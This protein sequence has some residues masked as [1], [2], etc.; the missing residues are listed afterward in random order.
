MG[1]KP[2]HNPVKGVPAPA[3]G[4][5]SV[6]SPQPSP[7]RR[8]RRRMPLTSSDSLQQPHQH[9]GPSSEFHDQPSGHQDIV[10]VSVL[11]TNQR[12]PPDIADPGCPGSPCPPDPSA[13]VDCDLGPQGWKR[14]VYTPLATHERISLITE[15]L[16]NRDEVEMVRRLCGDDAQAFVDVIYEARP[17]VLPSPKS[18]V[19]NFDSNFRGLSIRR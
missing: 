2:C 10:E 19:A 12:T 16:S 7:L 9:G 18:R 13:Q 8:P 15:I 4:A 14:L 3:T 11:S 6:S 17:Q 5:F 1:I